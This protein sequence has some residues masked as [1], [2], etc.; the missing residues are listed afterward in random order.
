[1]PCS[2]AAPLEYSKGQEMSGLR[3]KE[4][5]AR[6]NSLGRVQSLAFGARNYFLAREEG[7]GM[8]RATRHPAGGG[9]LGRPIADL[10]GLL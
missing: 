6:A 3:R 1:M 4:G 8:V 5:G 2:A 10:V 9:G 7:K